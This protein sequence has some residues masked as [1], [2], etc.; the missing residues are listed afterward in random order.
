[1][2]LSLAIPT[3]NE[4]E[5]IRLL[6]SKIQDQFRQNNIEGKIIVI[7]DN[8][9]DGTGK[10]I[11]EISKKQKNVKVI[12]REGKK[13]LSS[14]VL[15]G[16]KKAE[17]DILGVMDADLSHPCEKIPEMFRE[18]EKGQADLVIGSRY[19]KNGG[20]RGWGISRKIVSRAATLLARPFTSIKDPMSGFFMIK[21]KCLLHRDINPKGFKILL[22]LIIKADY[23]HS[24]EIPIIFNNRKK[25]KSKA[26]IKEMFYYALNLFRYALYKL[27][28]KI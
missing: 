4:R 14:A 19:I 5:N 3:Y 25:G 15:E 2:K 24:R 10:I 28:L 11:D 22:E 16:W 17:G 23:T 8:S 1:M 20:I 7:D 18:I 12:H 9:P 13:G 27:K 26:G 21:R 6:I